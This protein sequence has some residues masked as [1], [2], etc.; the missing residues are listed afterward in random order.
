MPEYARRSPAS[1]VPLWRTAAG[2]VAAYSVAALLVAWLTHSATART[3]PDAARDL[4]SAAMIW[5]ALT[6]CIALLV[7]HWPASRL[8]Y[9]RAALVYAV[10]IVG[11]SWGIN[12][13]FL[14]LHV[15]IGAASPDN[16]ADRLHTASIINLPFNAVAA[17]ALIA[18][19]HWRR[20]AQGT[21]AAQG[22]P[23][24]TV[25]ASVP[26]SLPVCSGRRRFS[27]PVDSIEWI[28]AADDYVIVHCTSGSHICSERL[29]RLE[30]TLA[31]EG[32]FR[33]H[34]SVLVNL[35]SVVALAGRPQTMR[36][37]MSS[38]RA[39]PVSRRRQRQVR[40]AVLHNRRPLS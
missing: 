35:H 28:E 1:G 36:L 18:V 4:W 17:A 14:A 20:S 12:G 33:V 3:W 2:V 31:E 8:G 21:K 27:V 19:F 5:A 25:K 34:R 37:E 24:A 39:V 38:G 22:A 32:F 40:Q 9:C 30:Q 6:G 11:A 23:V 13:V 29:Y 15:A 26:D 16:V 7:R 10:V